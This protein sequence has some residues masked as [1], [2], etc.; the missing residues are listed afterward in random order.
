MFHPYEISVC[1]N[2]WSLHHHKNIFW[3]SI[4]CLS[5]FILMNGHGIFF[6]HLTLL[7]ATKMKKKE[8]KLCTQDSNNFKLDWKLLT[9]TVWV[10][11]WAE[12]HFSDQQYL[13]ITDRGQLDAVMRGTQT[14]QIQSL[15]LHTCE[16]EERKKNPT[17]TF[18]LILLS[19]ISY[20]K[21]QWLTLIYHLRMLTTKM[22]CL[23][24][25]KLCHQ[26]KVSVI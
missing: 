6:L 4:N 2:P 23:F 18:S 12:V 26:K 15:Y 8:R 24:K 21:V 10:P 7:Y 16:G 3:Y 13:R 9:K 22:V 1:C 17:W 14:N 5:F 19:H 25:I 20:V 11:S